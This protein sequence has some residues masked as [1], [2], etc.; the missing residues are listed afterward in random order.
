MNRRTFFKLA[1]ASAAGLALGV[2]PD[3]EVEAATEKWKTTGSPAY[4]GSLEELEQEARTTSGL[5]AIHAAES[6]TFGVCGLAW[7]DGAE[8]LL[9]TRDGGTTWSEAMWAS[10]HGADWSSS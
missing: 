9:M 3:V 6:D 2:R 5:D 7:N 4:W 10:G 1:A 8:V